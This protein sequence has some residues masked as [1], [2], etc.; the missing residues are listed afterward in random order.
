M[1]LFIKNNYD[2]MSSM[3]YEV[4]NDIDHLTTGQLEV[5]VNSSELIVA[6]DPDYDLLLELKLRGSNSDNFFI[7][8]SGENNEREARDSII[9]RYAK[10]I[11]RCKKNEC[12]FVFDSFLSLMNDSESFGANIVDMKNH[13]KSDSEIHFEYVVGDITRDKIEEISTAGNVKSLLTTIFFDDKL[14]F[15]DI[16]CWFQWLNEHWNTTSLKSSYRKITMRSSS[17][18]LF[19]SLENTG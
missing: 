13:F 10:T 8:L 16:Q 5:Y 12:P 7:V 4:F 14:L 17:L 18:S 6:F 19:L 9:Y 2:E 15:N 1:I 3:G 11:I